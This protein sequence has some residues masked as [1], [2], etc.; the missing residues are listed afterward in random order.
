MPRITE[1]EWVATCSIC[2]RKLIRSHPVRVG[3]CC[4]LLLPYLESPCRSEPTSGGMAAQF[5]EG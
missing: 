1:A 3:S 2:S 4:G 5:A